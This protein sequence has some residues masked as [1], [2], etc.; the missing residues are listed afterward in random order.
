MWGLGGFHV[1]NDPAPVLLAA[2]VQRFFVREH[3]A[4]QVV[5]VPLRQIF[6]KLVKTMWLGPQDVYSI[7]LLSTLWTSMSSTLERS[8]DVVKVAAR[9]SGRGGNRRRFSNPSTGAYF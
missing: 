1:T 8:I 6:E 4:D 5:D 2:P 3:T 9:S 7:V